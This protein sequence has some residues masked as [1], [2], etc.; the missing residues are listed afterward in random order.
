MNKQIVITEKPS[1]AADIAKALGGF[2]K[3]GDHF[4][5][6]TMLI[7]AAAGHLLESVRP[8]TWALEA[9][10]ILPPQLDLVPKA[11][12]EKRLKDLVALLGRDDVVG[13][14]NAC[15]AGREGE[16]IFL[17]IM[18]HAGCKKPVQRL[19]LQSM[20]AAAIRR[21]FEELRSA[22]SVRGLADAAICRSIADWWIGIN[23]TK[24]LTGIMKRAGRYDLTSAGR[25]QTPT[26][27]M[28]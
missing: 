21:A 9:L 3:H 4:E 6:P 2:T 1:V 24:A 5:S 25:V 11:K 26:L 12:Q 17:E 23:M 10:P 22:E 14:I 16:L 27:I 15:D 28:V 8:K 20:T 18:Q 19:W 13:V 7:A